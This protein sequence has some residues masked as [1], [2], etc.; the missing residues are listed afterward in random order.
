[1][2]A[3]QLVGQ[4]SRIQSWGLLFRVVPLESFT[5]VNGDFSVLNL[6]KSKHGSQL[7]DL[8]LNG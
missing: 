3:V 6:N 8:T 4:L 7:M 1:M 5:F 2:L